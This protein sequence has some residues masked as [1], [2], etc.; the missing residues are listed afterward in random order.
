MEWYDN[1]DYWGQATIGDLK[2]PKI[3][4]SKP[5]FSILTNAL[6]RNTVVHETCHLIA[7][8]RLGKPVY[9]N[10][11]WR[12]LMCESG[13]ETEPDV[14]PAVYSRLCKTLGW[15]RVY[16]GCSVKYISHNIFNRIK[17]KTEEHICVDCNTTIKEH[18]NA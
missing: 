4:L 10:I 13:E 8:Y 6:R 15:V 12:T 1:L 11:T 16:C 5:I 9:H 7:S 3:Y 18:V 14:S 17:S 2:N